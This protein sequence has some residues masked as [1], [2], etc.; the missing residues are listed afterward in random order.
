MVTLDPLVAGLAA[1]AVAVTQ[2]GHREAFLPSLQH[3]PCAA[4]YD[5]SHSMASGIP[6]QV[7][8]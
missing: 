5:W 6:L 2:L 4:P 7:V 1:D 8:P 3:E